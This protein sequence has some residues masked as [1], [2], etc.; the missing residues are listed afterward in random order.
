MNEKGVLIRRFKRFDVGQ[1]CHMD[2][3]VTVLQRVCYIY[4]H[5]HTHTHTLADIPVVG[6]HLMIPIDGTP[7]L[8][9]LL[10]RVH[11]ECFRLPHSYA[12]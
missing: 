5:T 9:V 8:C 4:I 1:V 2:S 10:C 6:Q 7:G 11:S 12:P 3:K